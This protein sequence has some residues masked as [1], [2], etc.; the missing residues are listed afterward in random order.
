MENRAEFL[1]KLSE[2]VVLAKGQGDRITIEETTAYFSDEDLTEEQMELVF[3][4]LLSQKVVV[5]GYIKMT[6][7]EE[8]TIVYT[9]EEA[10]YLDEYMADLQAFSNEKDGERRKLFARLLSGDGN[11]KERLTQIYLKEVVEIAKEMYHPEIFLG[12]MIQE[13]NLGLVIALDM[14]EDIQSAETTIQNQIRQSIQMLI[15]EHTEVHRRDKKMVE[16]VTAL[17]EGIKALTEE[18]G[19]KVTIDEL[20]LYM[21]MSEEEISDVL[22]LM[23][24]ENEESEE[25]EERR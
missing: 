13:G 2:L 23:G 10:A 22:R 3:D 8:K 20:A 14:L 15:E 24:E 16:Q 17:D 4:Y 21:G 7:E 11:A 5:Q 1:K 9:E 19:R 12:D 6:D 25:T 18:L